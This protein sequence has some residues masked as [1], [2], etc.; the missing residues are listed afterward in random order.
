MQFYLVTT[1]ARHV[2]Y[3][4]LTPGALA[5]CY[6]DG[7]PYLG[8]A[9]LGDAGHAAVLLGGLVL[10]ERAFPAVREPAPAAA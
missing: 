1:A 7:L 6:A 2:L 5:A 4:P 8:Y 3:H 10:A 9:L